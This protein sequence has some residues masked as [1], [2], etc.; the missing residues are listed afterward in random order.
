MGPNTS[1]FQVVSFPPFT[2]CSPPGPPPLF[3]LAHLL[4]HWPPGL[5]PL[6]LH[7]LLPPW[8]LPAPP[9]RPSLPASPLAS[10]PS[11]L[12]L[13]RLLPPCPPLPHPS[14]FTPC[15]F[16]GL[17]PRPP[18]QAVHSCQAEH[19][20]L[21][22]PLQQLGRTPLRPVSVAPGGAEAES[23]EADQPLQP[24]S[25]ADKQ[26][27]STQELDTCIKAV[28]LAQF[29]LVLSISRWAGRGREGRVRGECV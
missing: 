17:P 10:P 2:A 24:L 27:L 26:L 29:N 18:R 25:D 23:A 4:P 11:P 12:T 8:P 16:R 28:G 22:E 15:S 6:P 5:P 9:P 20:S 19:E 21:S 14:P 7:H 3:N 1:M 13:H